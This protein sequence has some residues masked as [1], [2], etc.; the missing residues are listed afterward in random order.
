MLDAGS[1]NVM[2]FTWNTGNQNL[3]NDTF[4]I[5]TEDNRIGTLDV[6]NRWG[7]KIYS[8]PNYTDHWTGEGIPD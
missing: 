1:Q 4:K 5:R 3:T 6:Y 7:D 2:N 8:H